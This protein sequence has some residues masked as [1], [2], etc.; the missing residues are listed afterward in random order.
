MN[1]GYGVEYDYI[2]PRELKPSLETKRIENLFLAGQING[3]T[4]YEEAACQG[5]IA[6][7]NSVRK[8]NDQEPFI[9]SRTEGYIGVLID[10]LTTQGTSEPYRMFTGRSE[11]RLSLRSDNADL[12]LTEKGYQAGVVKDYRYKKFKIFK[13]SYENA[14]NYLGSLSNS[15]AFWKSKI[16]SLPCEVDNPTNKS[17]TDLLRITGV[18]IKM[19]EDFL[20][21]N[22]RYLIEDIKM[23]ER[24]KIHCVYS[25]GER[26]QNSE[27]D[28]IRKNESIRLP[29]D[30]DYSKINISNEAREKLYTHRPSSLG[31]ASRIPGITPSAIFQILKYVKNNQRLRV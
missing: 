14:L 3:T 24:I 7:I 30:F 18:S 29:I 26:K 27:M 15:V 19:F 6:G 17:V 13:S 21:N 10:D 25:E 4:G 23:A 5:L 28:D 20:P 22:Y 8:I 11:Y 2:D 16:P 31:A 12:R 1:L 9:V